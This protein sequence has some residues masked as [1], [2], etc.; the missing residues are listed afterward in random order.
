[1]VGLGSLPL[2]HIVYGGKFDSVSPLLKWYVLLPVVMGVGNAAN[3]AL[4][5]VEK[6]ECVF[7]AYV[8]SGVATFAL[9]IPLVIY[10][11]IRGAVFGMLLSGATYAV[12]MSLSFYRFNES[13]GRT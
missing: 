3:A 8:M 13:R 2:L 6:P 12:A 4:K 9:G 1:M 5:A 7:Y 10:M 11:G